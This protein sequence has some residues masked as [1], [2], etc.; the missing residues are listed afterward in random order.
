V[1][2]LIFAMSALSERVGIMAVEMYSSWQPDPATAQEQHKDHDDGCAT[3]QL[4]VGHRSGP[5]S[6]VRPIKAAKNVPR[7]ERCH[8]LLWCKSHEPV[9]KLPCKCTPGAICALI[10]G[11]TKRC[12]KALFAACQCGPPLRSIAMG[13]VPCWDPRVDKWCI[14]F[15]ADPE[16]LCVPGKGQLTDGTTC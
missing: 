15:G 11:R 4:I 7:L 3:A 13:F 9:S 12:S 16:G 1:A 2:L 14:Q 6:L 5:V 10:A 8:S